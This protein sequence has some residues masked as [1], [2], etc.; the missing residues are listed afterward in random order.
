MVDYSI[1]ETR[2]LL[3]ANYLGL[4]QIMLEKPADTSRRAQ[5]LYLTYFKTMLREMEE[6]L[7]EE[8]D[9]DRMREVIEKA[10]R[11]HGLY[12]ELWEYRKM[13]PSPVPNIFNLYIYGTKYTV[14]GQ[15]EGITVMQKLIDTAR[16][17]SRPGITPHPRRSLAPTGRTCST[18]TILWSSSTGWRSGG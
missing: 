10:N 3:T 4:P 7:E 15:D 17:G 12:D 1:F 16:E 11:A 6:F 13:V 8:L 18:T 2:P 14:W 9:E 5:E